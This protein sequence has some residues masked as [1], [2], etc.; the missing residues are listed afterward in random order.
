MELEGSAEA[1]DVPLAGDDGRRLVDSERQQVTSIP[2]VE[3][4]QLTRA[5]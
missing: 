5:E 4:A 1:Q 3:R 2:S